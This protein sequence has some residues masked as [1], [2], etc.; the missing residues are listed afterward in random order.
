MPEMMPP[1]GGAPPGA[2]PSA[3]PPQAT[4]IQPATSPVPEHGLEAAAL[5]KLSLFVQ[6]LT[7]LLPN[8]PVGSDLAKDVREAVNK[9]A[10]HVPPGA[11]SPGIQM[12]EAQ[13]QLLMTRQNAP[14]IQA[15]RA[16][17]MGSGG[18]APPGAPGGGEPP[19]P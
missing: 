14:Q 9:L 8:I 2:P 16:A 1:G 19:P 6:A 7:H 12:S 18:G 5:A 15:A 10:K 4:G 17:Q 3:P 11:V 13:R